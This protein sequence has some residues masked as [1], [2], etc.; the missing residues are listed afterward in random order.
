[1][2]DE[3]SEVRGA[4]LIQVSNSFILIDVRCFCISPRV[5]VPTTVRAAGLEK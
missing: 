5:H 4:E 3:S 2:R 1:M